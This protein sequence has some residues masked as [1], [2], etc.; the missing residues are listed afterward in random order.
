M[1]KTVIATALGLV[2]IGAHAQ[3]S[4]TLYGIIDTG[5]AYMN[6][7]KPSS[8]PAGAVTAMSEGVWAGD[9]WGVKGRE[10]LGGGTAA[11]FQLENGFNSAS[12]A[13]GKSGLMFDRGAWVG[14]TNANF[15]T[16]TAGRQYTSYYQM[17]SAWSPTNWLSG[18]FGAHAGDIDNLDTD[19]R[20]NNALVYT[21]PVFAG[22]TVSGTY[23]LGGQAGNFSLGQSWSLGAQYK[24]GGAGLAV[25][26][27]R[28]NNAAVGGG[29]WSSSST[30]YS[31]TGEQGN[32]SLTAGYQT[33]AAQNRFAATGGYTFGQFDVSAAYSNV[34]YLPGVNS[35]A[36]FE[37]KAIFNT[38][39][40]VLHY[41][42]S[43]VWDFAG[44]YSYTRATTANGIASAASYN[45][46]NLTQLYN[47]SK[48]TRLYA[49]EAYQ[50]ANGQ[51]LSSA[52]K[53]IAAT[54]NIGDQGIGSANGRGQVGVTVGIN[55]QF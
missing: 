33:S 9:R 14:L 46:F 37:S 41:H 10:D 54:A 42:A 28:F 1:K 20:V 47:L 11:I 2:A 5:V 13:T 49:L 22:L 29:A 43:T 24:M 34:Q 25:G 26:Y 45:Q 53:V 30:A 39:G 21:S 35:V 12:G 8:G 50:R 18:Y 3:S 51:T 7:V 4:V 52:G 32:S 40:V 15:G 48:R 23:A 27:E 55:H 17:L 16:L 44:G 36:G 6:S 19:Y 31:G 38:G